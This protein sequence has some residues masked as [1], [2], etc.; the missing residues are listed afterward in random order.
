MLEKHWEEEAAMEEEIQYEPIHVEKSRRNAAATKKRA[1]QKNQ[2][3]QKEV[4]LAKTRIDNL[5][6]SKGNVT[7]NDILNSLL[8]SSFQPKK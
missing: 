4:S 1:T 7:P 5:I 6:Q 2:K 3:I 8:P